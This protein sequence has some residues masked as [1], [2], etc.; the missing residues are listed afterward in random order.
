M[1]TRHCS[2]EPARLP[3]SARRDTRPRGGFGGVRQWFRSDAARRAEGGRT[4]QRPGIAARRPP[5]RPSPTPQRPLPGPD[6]PTS[7]RPLGR[8]PTRRDHPGTSGPLHERE[9]VPPRAGITRRLASRR[10]RTR[11]SLPARGSPVAAT[12]PGRRRLRPSPR[13]GITP[14]TTRPCEESGTSLPARGDHPHRSPRAREG[15]SI[16]PRARGSPFLPARLGASVVRPSPRAGITPVA[17]EETR[18]PSTSLPARGDHPGSTCSPGRVRSVP[19]RA[20]GSP[21]SLISCA[22]RSARPSPR[23]GIPRLT[24]QLRD[25]VG[26]S[27]PARGDPPP[28]SASRAGSVSSLPARGDHPS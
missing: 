10:I 1:R 2:T 7:P 5:R 27:L 3:E 25:Q 13:A 23:A 26:A 24:D 14:A 16:P 22:T 4:R 20:R 17:V 12:A 15:E 6:G 11:T 9:R 8:F 19:P 21:A 28:S 18:S